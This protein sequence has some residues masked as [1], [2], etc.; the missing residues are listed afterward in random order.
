[1]VTIFF[2][3]HSRFSSPPNHHE[4]SDK[5]GP[6]RATS[7]LFQAACFAFAWSGVFARFL[8]KFCSDSVPPNNVVNIVESANTISPA[9]LPSGGIQSNI[10][11]S[12]FPASVK[13]CG[14]DIS[15]GCLART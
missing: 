13:G 5:I 9:R 15:I 7:I 6:T 1:M 11:N 2:G 12:R 14:R 8:Q 4:Y 3:K 10:L